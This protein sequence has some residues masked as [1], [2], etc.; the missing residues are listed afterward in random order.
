MANR[1]WMPLYVADYLADTSHL[2]A[3]ESGCYLHL[4]MHYWQQGGLPDDDRKLAAIAKMTMREWNAAKPTII[5]FFDEN[6]RHKRID[7]ELAKAQEISSKRSA[8]A[9]QKQSKSS[10]NAPANAEQLDTHARA[11]SQSQSQSQKE[12]AASAAP[13]DPD[14]ELFRRGREVFGSDAGS[15]IA[16]LKKAK[17]GSV[18]LA[19][20]AIEQA[21]VKD[22]P[23]E[24]IGAIIRGKEPENDF[25]AN[26]MA[27]VL[28]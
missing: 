8:S 28:G 4:I 15:L 23:R 1:P 10:A 27:G 26:P 3:A 22:R 5:E 12:D 2:R 20:A 24:Y 25:Y 14:A 18:P 21:S 9:K 6:M 13:V 19:R 16:K 11:S 17:N 7:A